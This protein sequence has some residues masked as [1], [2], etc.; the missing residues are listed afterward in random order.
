MDI[1]ILY[2]YVLL[3]RAKSLTRAAELAYMT[4]QAYTDSLTKLENEL[5]VK[6]LERRKRGFELTAAGEE[7]LRYLKKWL[8]EWEA[9]MNTLVSLEKREKKT[10]RIGVGFADLSPVFLERMIRFEA[11][12][13]GVRVEY[14][15]YSPQECFAL[16]D[17]GSV[18][19]VCALDSGERPGCV[20]MRLPESGTQPLL[21][22]HESHP[23]AKKEAVTTE[24]LR[25]V[26][27]VMGNRS[28]TPDPL[29]DRYAKP[30]GAIP[31]YVPIRNN[32]YALSVMKQR[33]AVGLSTSRRPNRYEKE[34]FVTRPLVDYPMGLSCY[35]YCRE[36][37][38]ETVKRFVAFFVGR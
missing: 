11:L 16:L 4:R 22:M 17:G 27:M 31:L 30:F 35:V 26:P 18:D 19:A 14:Q 28:M 5:G 23:L 7:L 1:G 21:M 15:D 32:S 24:D 8:P 37:A 10:I 34:G 9:E 25:G 29:L 33:K 12:H 20:R 36:N 6:L 3:D 38:P 2:R 13:E